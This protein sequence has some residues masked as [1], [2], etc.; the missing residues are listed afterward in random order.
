[1]KVKWWNVL[2]DSIG[3]L[4]ERSDGDLVLRKLT[5]FG[6][7]LMNGEMKKKVIVFILVHSNSIFIN[8]SIWKS[9]IFSANF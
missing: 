2:F 7:V 8:I 4:R 9:T 5:I 6:C 3:S 1:M